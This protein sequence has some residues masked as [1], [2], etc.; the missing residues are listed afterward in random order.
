MGRGWGKEKAGRKTERGR[1]IGDGREM[2][3]HRERSAE[4]GARCFSH[5][6]VKELTKTLL[7]YEASHLSD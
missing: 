2:V 4:I 5:L 6:H 3:D 7:F 1:W